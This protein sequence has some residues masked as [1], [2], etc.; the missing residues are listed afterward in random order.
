MDRRERKPRRGLIV[1]FRGRGFWNVAVVGDR[2]QWGSRFQFYRGTAR[3]AENGGDFRSDDL[4][5]FK[6]LRAFYDR[7]AAAA[8]PKLRAAAINDRLQNFTRDIGLLLP[9]LSAI[10]SYKH[11]AELA[12][13]DGLI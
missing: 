3:R 8:H 9:G 13:C 11:S 2:D 1:L 7:A 10:V 6:G 12:D 5:R 4:E